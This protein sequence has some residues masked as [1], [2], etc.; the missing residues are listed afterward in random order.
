[1][2]EIDSALTRNNILRIIGAFILDETEPIHQL[3]LSDST[4]AILVKEIFDFLSASYC[5]LV[6][7]S[8][9]RA[10]NAQ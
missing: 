2:G 10:T 7:R 8:Q 5:I 3:D 1:V 4:M 6:S 9:F